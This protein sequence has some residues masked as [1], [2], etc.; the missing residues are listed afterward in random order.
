M[1]WRT[2]SKRHRHARLRSQLQKSIVF[3]PNFSGQDADHFHS[4][5][6]FELLI[7]NGLLFFLVIH[8]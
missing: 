4:W 3:R 2:L 6:A 7:L 5:K 1:F 8:Y